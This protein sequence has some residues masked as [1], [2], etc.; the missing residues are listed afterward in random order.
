MY[1][2]VAC[3]EPDQYLLCRKSFFSKLIRQQNPI[4]QMNKRYGKVIYGRLRYEKMLNINNGDEENEVKI[5]RA[6]ILYIS[7]WKNRMILKVKI[8]GKDIHPFLVSIFSY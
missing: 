1:F 5:I 2:E 4:W 3:P 6:N 8:W 7:D